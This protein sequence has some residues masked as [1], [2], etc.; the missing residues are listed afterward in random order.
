MGD[1]NR[2]QN[3]FTFFS[4]VRSQLECKQRAYDVDLPLAVT[5]FYQINL[6]EKDDILVRSPISK[7]CNNLTLRTET[8]SLTGRG[9][10]LY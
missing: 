3:F 5:H 1:L 8:Y 7:L 2:I 9:V 4:I 6:Y 10:A